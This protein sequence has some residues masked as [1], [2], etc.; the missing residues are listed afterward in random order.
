M[1]MP[2]RKSALEIL[3]DPALQT[4]ADDAAQRLE[5]E[6]D[7]YIARVR[8]LEAHP[9]NRPGTDKS[10]VERALTEFQ[11]HYRLARRIA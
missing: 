6:W 7:E 11:Q 10:W 4:A 9:C 3:D 8:R 2:Q 1:N 5:A